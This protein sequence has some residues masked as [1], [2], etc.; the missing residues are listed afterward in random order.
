M[1]KRPYDNAPYQGRG[2]LPDV[3]VDIKRSR[4]DQIGGGGGGGGSGGG[5]SGG[6]GM[7]GE[8]W[9]VENKNTCDRSRLACFRHF[10]YQCLGSG[11]YG[12]H[13]RPRFIDAKSTP[14]FNDD[15]FS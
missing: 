10:R 6:V 2:E 5:S 4:S 8:H 13:H 9:S 11:S 3:A 1:H 14:R 12:I 7:Y 15:I